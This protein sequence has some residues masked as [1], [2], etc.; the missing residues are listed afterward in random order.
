MC[1]TG[2]L[3]PAAIPDPLDTFTGESQFVPP[4]ATL[5]KKISPPAAAFTP[6]QA[7]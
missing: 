7:T 4:L 1:G 6:A 2:A 5:L 3:L